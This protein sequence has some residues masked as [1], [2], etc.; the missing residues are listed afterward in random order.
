MV[1]GNKN[2]S[3]LAEARWSGRQPEC[4][5]INCG[6]PGRR[7]GYFVQTNLFKLFYWE[8]FWILLCRDFTLL[9]IFKFSKTL[10]IKLLWHAPR[11]RFSAKRL[12]WRLQDHAARRRHVQMLRRDE[13]RGGLRQVANSKLIGYKRMIKP[14]FWLILLPALNKEVARRNMIDFCSKE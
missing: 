3:C 13:V 8:T 10:F 7:K 11:S 4:R 2:R 9:R 6:P 12:D 5:E 14:I 1:V